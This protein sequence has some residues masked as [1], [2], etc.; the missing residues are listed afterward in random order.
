MSEPKI[1]YTK[2][3]NIYIIKFVGDIR[4]TMA[5]A[6]D[7]F[8]NKLFRDTDYNGILLDL[9]EVTCID[10]TGLGL[11]A[12]VANFVRDRFET[13]T[14][15]VSTN[16]DINHILNSVGFYEI[17]HICDEI[18]VKAETLQPI[19]NKNLSKSGLSKTLFDSHHTLSQLNSKNRETFK[20][21]IGILRHKV[22]NE[23]L[24]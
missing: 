19:P 18:P 8:L 22:V 2:Q 16:R 1:L 5:Y 9:T 12:K 4:Y 7:E 10:S 14:T 13:Q 17:F 3:G 11:L 6:L 24:P 21:V 20:D 23:N 15:L